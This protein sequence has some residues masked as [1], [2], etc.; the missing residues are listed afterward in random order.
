MLYESS[1]TDLINSKRIDEVT[2]ENR[3]NYVFIQFL[4]PALSGSS[5]TGIISAC[6]SFL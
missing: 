4:S 6:I 5:K 1:E 3:H 2:Q